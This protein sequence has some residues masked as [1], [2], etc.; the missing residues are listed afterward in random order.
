M[1]LRICGKIPVFFSLLFLV[2]L[3]ACSGESSS[4][5]ANFNSGEAGASF[6]GGAITNIT[7][8]ENG[9]GTID[10]G[11]A[12]DGE[13]YVLMLYHYDADGAT[14]ALEVGNSENA[15][16]SLT[17][18]LENADE[19]ITEDFHDQLREMEASLPA[20]EGARSSSTVRF[21]TS[22]T[23]YI[24]GDTRSFKVI[25]S[26]AGTS[27]STITAVLRYKTSNF[28]YWIDSRDSSDLSDDEV[29]EIM[30]QFDGVIDE[31]KNI[32]G[33]VSD[34]DGDGRFNILSTR[35]VNEMGASSGGIITGFFYAIDLLDGY[36]QSNGCEIYYTMVP[37]SDGDYGVTV[38]KEFTLS[39]LLPSV[40]PHEFQ[41]MLNFNNHYFIQDDSIEESFLNEGL[42]HM[43]EDIYSD[44]AATGLE[45]PARVLGYLANTE[46]LCITC[47]SSLY[48]RGGIYLLLRFLFDQAERGNIS[49]VTNGK[50]L[51]SNLSQTSLTGVENIIDSVYGSTADTQSYMLGL[52]GQFGL[53]IFLDN[54][55]LSSDSRLAL[56]AINLR[57]T[58]DDNRNTTLS[59]PELTSL[60]S[61]G[62]TDT[63]AG[64][65]VFYLRLTSETI[66]DFDGT[67]ALNLGNNTNYGA[68]LI[69]TGI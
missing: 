13:E 26:T 32:F 45:N 47:G 28:L 64:T 58:Q 7:L 3:A 67:I 33:D 16:G 68:Y 15:P 51:L 65:T 49:N 10:L 61:S 29:E 25:Q 19:N 43:A 5:Q 44:F 48:Q 12:G 35:E 27:T 63:M 50:E 8:D 23:S 17:A 21:A 57:S 18:L 41:H 66:N 40:L 62:L 30:E 4:G 14:E 60:S 52:M 53:A 11:E 38:S 37:D 55:A 46:N 24:V 2:F 36:S 20:Y 69:Q 59:G 56:D 9:S 34:V 31:E 6:E 54:T 1:I 22:D 39:N 42:S